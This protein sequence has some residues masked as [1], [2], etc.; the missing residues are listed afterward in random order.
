MGK[1]I[2]NKP[3]ASKRDWCGHFSMAAAPFAKDIADDDL[4]VPSSKKIHVDRI[5]SAVRNRNHVL[6][7]GEPGLG[8]TCLLRAVRRKLPGKRFRLTYMHNASLGQ[9]DFYRLLCFGLGLTPS[10]TPA[11]S[12]RPSARD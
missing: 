10:A 12:R 5:L 2:E 7:T 6:L 11:R 3:A 1:A 9:R 4:W 8:K